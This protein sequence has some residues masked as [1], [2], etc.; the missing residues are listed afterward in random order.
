[1]VPCP[2]RLLCHPAG[3]RNP[4]RSAQA[5]QHTPFSSNFSG[6]SME[7]A[8]ILKHQFALPD[9]TLSDARHIQQEKGGRLGDI[10]VQRQAITETQLLEALSVQYE[11]PF[12][13]RTAHGKHHG[14]RFRQEDFDSIPQAPP[15]GAPGRC[16]TPAT[17]RW[18]MHPRTGLYRGGQRSGQLQ[19]GGRSDPNPGS[20]ELQAGSFHQTVHPGG[21][22]PGLRSEPGFGRAAGPGHGR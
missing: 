15:H 21:D 8:H 17:G 13:A 11:I 1:M 5:D 2:H 14:Q 4:H 10:L 22:Q 18:M 19:R 20:G 16:P 9:D 6:E 3:R 7:L 12:L